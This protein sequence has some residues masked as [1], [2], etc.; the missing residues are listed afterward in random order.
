[1]CACVCVMVSS[2]TSTTRELANEHDTQC[3]HDFGTTLTHTH[4]NSFG[5]HLHHHARVHTCEVTVPFLPEYM[6]SPFDACSQR[7][8][9]EQHE[10]VG[11]TETQHARV[12]L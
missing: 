5:E 6:V 12:Q 10:P 2:S 8:V 1:M 7:G 4:T 3:L 9:R 11:T